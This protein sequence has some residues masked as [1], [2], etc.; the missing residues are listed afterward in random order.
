M[1][2]TFAIRKPSLALL[3]MSPCSL[4]VT[5][6][7]RRHFVVHYYDLRI[8]I[9]NWHLKP[10]SVSRLRERE[11]IETTGLTSISALPPFY[12]WHLQVT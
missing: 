8:L 10:V 5:L 9:S 3:L 12:C 6:N 4:E 11:Q 7:E 2:P 1:G